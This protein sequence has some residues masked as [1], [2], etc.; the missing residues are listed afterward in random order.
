MATWLAYLSLAIGGL[1]IALLSVSYGQDDTLPS[2]VED[3][4]HEKSHVE[5]ALHNQLVHPLNPAQFSRAMRDDFPYHY[6]IAV[7]MDEVATENLVLFDIVRTPVQRRILTRDRA[8]G[9]GIAAD[10]N[11]R[12]EPQPETIASGIFDIEKQATY[13]IAI[14]ESG[15]NTIQSLTRQ[16]IAEL[17]S[18]DELDQIGST[19]RPRDHRPPFIGG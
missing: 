18:Y 6:G 14:D 19:T 13:I 3:N 16:H 11:R 5:G 10:D 9:G 2:A 8:G 12:E 4:R 15:R 7:H 17:R 1:L